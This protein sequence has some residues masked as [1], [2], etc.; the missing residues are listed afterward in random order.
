MLS[1]LAGILFDDKYGGKFLYIYIYK[2][3]SF[4]DPH[5]FLNHANFQTQAQSPQLVGLNLLIFIPS[6]VLKHGREIP[7]TWK[8]VAGKIIYKRDRFIFPF[9]F[10][11]KPSFPTHVLP[12]RRC[13]PITVLQHIS[14]FHGAGSYIP[15]TAIDFFH[16]PLVNCPI[17]MENHHF[18]W[19]NSLFLW[20]CSIAFC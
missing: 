16:Y 14:T 7:L 19:D 20:P 9:P 11:F 5:L 18:S 8:S 4:I 12:S 3:R 15:S 10:S 2:C 1:D 6:G 13:F 17:T